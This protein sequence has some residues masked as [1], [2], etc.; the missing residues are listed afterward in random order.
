MQ[1]KTNVK[2]VKALNIFE[3]I[4]KLRGSHYEPDFTPRMGLPTQ[5]EPGTAEKVELIRKRL[6][7]GEALFHPDDISTFDGCVRYV[8]PSK[9][10]DAV[11]HKE[12]IRLD[13]FMRRM[14]P[15]NGDF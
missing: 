3:A 11:Y 8:K 7:L 4:K 15:D 2:M 1:Q 14:F 5:F 13:Q 6:E 10:N 9:D 12:P